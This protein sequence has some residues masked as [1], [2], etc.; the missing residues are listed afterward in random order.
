MMSK[1]S[2]QQHMK[3]LIW[4]GIYSNTP[5]ETFPTEVGSPKYLSPR[6]STAISSALV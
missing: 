2:L 6:A 3:P 1:F 5:S 4:L